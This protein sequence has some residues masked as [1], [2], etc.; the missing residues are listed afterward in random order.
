M[1][2]AESWGTLSRFSNTFFA[3]V[4]T[5]IFFDHI[6]DFSIAV[7]FGAGVLVVFYG[8]ESFSYERYF[9]VMVADACLKSAAHLWLDVLD[10]ECVI[11]YFYFELSG[12]H[13]ICAMHS[14][15]IVRHC[16]GVISPDESRSPAVLARLGA[17]YAGAGCIFEKFGLA[18]MRASVGIYTHFSA[19]C[20][21]NYKISHS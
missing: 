13:V 16:C 19:A 3:E 11:A 8:V 15:G 14:S 6:V 21:A 1:P 7:A 12:E 18:A 5:R 2:W 10:N 4:D 20:G 17:D 9:V